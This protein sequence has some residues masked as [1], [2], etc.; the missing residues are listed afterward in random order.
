MGFAMVIGFTEHLQI[1]TTST[2]NAL[3]NLHTL[4]LTTAHAKSSQSAVFSPV[5]AW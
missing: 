5:A 3:V 2:Y 4:L 1:V